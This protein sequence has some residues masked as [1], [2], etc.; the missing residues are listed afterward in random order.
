VATEALGELAQCHIADDE[1]VEHLR[2]FRPKPSAKQSAE[3]E[4]LVYSSSW[5]QGY[6]RSLEPL[7]CFFEQASLPE[8]WRFL[9]VG[10]AV[11]QLVP[12]LRQM[13]FTGRYV[14]IDIGEQFLSVARRRAMEIPW[15][16]LFIQADGT[17]LPFANGAFDVVF[18]RST[19]WALHN[20]KQ[21]LHEIL[22]VSSKYVILLD[23]PFHQGHEKTAY[24]MQLSKNHTAMLS[25]FSRETFCTQ[26][27]SSAKVCITPGE[28]SDVLNFGA[29]RW[30]NV[31]IELA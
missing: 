21:A 13:H 27:P 18:S 2:K 10:S 23:T 9:D 5:N 7:R 12:H 26:L 31:F 4:R 8:K 14:G 22:R 1:I 20:W 17:C 6:E 11:G 19:L 29:F 25:T 28:E 30:H 15:P 16:A 24:F 3:L